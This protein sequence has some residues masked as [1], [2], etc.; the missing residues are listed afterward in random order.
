MD[1]GRTELDT[2]K[3]VAAI[4]TFVCQVPAI[5]GPTRDSGHLTRGHGDEPLGG[6][7]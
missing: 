3:A 2:D 7:G 1:V 4:L 6:G 5:F